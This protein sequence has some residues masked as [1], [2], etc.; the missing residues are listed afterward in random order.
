MSY[1]YLQGF[2]SV[3][4]AVGVPFAPG[5]SAAGGVKHVVAYDT[6]K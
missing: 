5:T 3:K 1:I 2:A 4:D 6:K